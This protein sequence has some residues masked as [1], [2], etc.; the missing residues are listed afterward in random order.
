L[1]IAID[2]ETTIEELV[3]LVPRAPALLRRFG[4]VCV[5][6]GEPV[7]GTLREAAAEKG[8]YD[9]DPV[10]AALREETVSG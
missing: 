4:I 6:C 8:V 10:L 3:E 1:A 7:W 2:P 5:Q 9:L